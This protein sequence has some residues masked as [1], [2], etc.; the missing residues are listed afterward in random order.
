MVLDLRFNNF[1]FKVLFF[2]ALP[3]FGFGSKVGLGFESKLWPE[4]G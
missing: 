1:E 2:G 3:T 4:K